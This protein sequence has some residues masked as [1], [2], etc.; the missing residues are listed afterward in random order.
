MA[1]HVLSL[2]IPDTLNKCILRIVDTSVYAPS[3]EVTCPLLQIT[4]PGFIH[5]INLSPPKINPGFNVN[6]T[7]CDLGLQSADCGTTFYDIPDGIYIVKYSVEPKDLVYVEYNHLRITCALNGIRNVY[8][9][10]NLGAC[11]PSEPQEE[12]LNKLRIIQQQLQAAKAYVEDCHDPKRGMELYKYAVSQL[13]KLTCNTNC[14][15]C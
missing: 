11:A 2:D 5:P 12:K 9:E 4:V 15:T 1:R 7:A 3:V 8:C 14:K 13:N 10:M 6:L